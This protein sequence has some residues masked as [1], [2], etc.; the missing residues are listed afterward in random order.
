M[1]VFILANLIVLVLE[2]AHLN[3]GWLGSSSVDISLH[4]SDGFLVNR[5]LDFGGLLEVVEVAEEFEKFRSTLLDVVNGDVAIF[6]EVQAHPVVADQHSHILVVL[7]EV[8]SEAL[9]VLNENLHK[10]GEHVLAFV[11]DDIE[12]AL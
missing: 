10:E 1:H 3:V 4:V 11:V 2:N 8:F 9:L 6:V 7:S 12:I 5:A